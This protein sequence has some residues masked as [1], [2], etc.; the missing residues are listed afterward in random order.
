MGTIFRSLAAVGCGAMM[1]FAAFGD[2]SHAEG[3]GSDQDYSYGASPRARAPLDLRQSPSTA[4]RPAVIERALALRG[5]SVA[6]E[7]EAS[8]APQPNVAAAQTAERPGW[9]EQER[10]G[11]PYQAHGA[12]F[13][14]AAEPGYSETGVASWYGDK[15]HGRPTASGEVFDQ[16]ALSAAHPTLPLPSLVQVTNL[17]TGAEV[18][19]RVNDRGPFTQ[20]RIIDVSRRAAEVLG[21]VGAGEARVHV[22]YLGPAP[23][24]VGDVSEAGPQPAPR[25]TAPTQR[26][27]QHAAGEGRY[28][29][30]VGAFGAAANATRAQQRVRA[31]GAA[32]IEVSRAGA[33][34]V[35]KVQVGP[36]AS[37]AEAEAAQRRIADLG[38]DDALIVAVAQR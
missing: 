21:F 18:I 35:H 33:R 2:V 31:A 30:Q 8:A 3:V 12:W 16:T 32:R 36:W 1:A 25:A 4:S 38:F 28:V 23:R 15:F 24:R 14:P 9:L 17:A 37:R 10:V 13:V 29:V 6:D 34:T 7:S 26:A 27:A 11:A 20:G 5:R 19:V 22:R